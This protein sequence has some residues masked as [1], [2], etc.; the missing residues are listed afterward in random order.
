M[1]NMELLVMTGN[2]GRDVS[3][4]FT[5]SGKLVGEFSV[6]VEVGFGD[7]KHTE[8]L[9]CVIWG[10]KDKSGEETLLFARWAGKGTKVLLR[11]TPKVECW[12]AKDGGEAKGKMVLTVTDWRI[13]SGGKAK[14][15]AEA[16]TPFDDGPQV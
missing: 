5:P 2:L 12:I 11:G 6:A 3:E 9:D 4:K 1:N 7:N 15:G 10:Q 8:W 14:N 16:A 13:L